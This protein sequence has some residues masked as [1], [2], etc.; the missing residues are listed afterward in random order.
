ML[1]F[2][3]ISTHMQAAVV[4]WES[5]GLIGYPFDVYNSSLVE[6]LTGEIDEYTFASNYAHALAYPA[7][8]YDFRIE[9]LT[10]SLSYKKTG[11]KV[12]L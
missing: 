10:H 6:L 9:S 8:L 3:E 5:D 11:Q 2:D 4:F 7:L 12:E 1:T